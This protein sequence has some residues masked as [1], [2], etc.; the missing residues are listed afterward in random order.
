[1]EDSQ[2]QELIYIEQVQRMQFQEFTDAWDQYMSE[3]ES[4]AQS[5]I[6]KLREEQEAEL[7]T[8]RS[9]FPEI[10]QRYRKSKKLIDMSV[11]EQKS[12]KLKQYDYASKFIQ[13]QEKLE[14]IER[15][16]HYQKQ[17]EHMQLLE[18]MQKIKH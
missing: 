17:L 14:I 9:S 18:N 1:M 10:A 5:N 12:N 2:Q 8:F 11:K 15:D 13:E 4:T 7:T 3:Y 6:A 16:L